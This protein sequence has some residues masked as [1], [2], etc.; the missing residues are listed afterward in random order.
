MK[1]IV[2]GANGQLGWEV[3]HRG[4]KQGFEIVALDIPEFDITDSYAVEKAVSR[5]GISLVINASAY[6]AVDKAESEPELAF[7]V[8]RDGPA[9]LA[10]SC[11]KIGLP[12]IHIN[13]NYGLRG[14]SG[15]TL[16]S[17]CIYCLGLLV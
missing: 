14:N 13:R 11:A 1:A 17:L 12:L 7:A 3:C 4:A 5:S 16:F 15:D 9:Y 2:I 10:S 6:T 8:N